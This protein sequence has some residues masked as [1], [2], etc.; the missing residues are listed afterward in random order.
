MSIEFIHTEELP[1][2]HCS[3]VYADATRVLKIPFQ[4]EEMTSGYHA[5][6]QMSEI[7]GPKVYDGDPATGAVLMERLIPGTPL[8]NSGLP[9]VETLAITC[10]LTVK[11]QGL[12]TEGCMPLVEFVDKAD[13][14]TLRL[15]KTSPAEVFLHG[16]LHHENI[17]LHGDRWVVIDPKGLIG[18]PHF[19]PTA[20]LRNPLGVV[21]FL[22]NLEEVLRRRIHLFAHTLDLDPWRICAWSLVD[23]RTWSE[24][25]WLRVVETLEKIE[26]SLRP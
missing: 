25:E 4:G 18:D 11:I 3:R 26:K 10:D 23:L 14:L 13:P 21:P 8:S 22:P 1:G 20:F 7:V 9:E 24:D 2:G 15:L 19:E 17:L 16:D 6:L 5:A 12:P